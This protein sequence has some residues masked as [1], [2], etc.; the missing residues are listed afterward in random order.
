M[1]LRSGAFGDLHPAQA[2]TTTAENVAIAR[3]LPLYVKIGDPKF[4]CRADD[5]RLENPLSSTMYD[6]VAAKSFAA[7]FGCWP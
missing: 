6:F 5:G 2:I 1:D 7:R 4:F 3:I